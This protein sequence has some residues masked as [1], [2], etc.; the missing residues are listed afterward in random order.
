[1]VYKTLA[2]IYLGYILLEG[3]FQQFIRG[4]LRFFFVILTFEMLEY[5]YLTMML[6]IEECFCLFLQVL[7]GK[8]E[9][10]KQHRENIK[11]LNSVVEHQ[12]KDLGRLQVDMNELEEKNRSIQAALDSAYK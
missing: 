6:F 2:M 7:D 12:E 1:M 5:S 11:K 8:E 9:V 3:C 10:E 4:M